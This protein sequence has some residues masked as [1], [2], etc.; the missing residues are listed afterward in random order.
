MNNPQVYDMNVICNFVE[1][2]S[3]I[4]NPV[5]VTTAN[6]SDSKDSGQLPSILIKKGLYSVLLISQAPL[7]RIDMLPRICKSEVQRGPSYI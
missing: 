2:Q 6:N 1:T 5:K 7:R 3:S 4:V